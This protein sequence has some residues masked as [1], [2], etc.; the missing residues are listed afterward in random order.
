[1][2]PVLILIFPLL[3]LVFLFVYYVLGLKGL[4]NE[5][6]DV[7]LLSRFPY[8][9]LLEKK[10]SQRIVQTIVFFL[11][12][13]FFGFLP[14]Y[15]T[16]TYSE[17]EGLRS[18]IFGIMMVNFLSIVALLYMVIGARPR[19]PK[20]FLVIYIIY[21]TLATASFSM[22]GIMM[23][24]L[25]KQNGLLHGTNNSLHYLFP[26]LS[27]FFALSEIGLLFNPGLKRWDRLE[28]VTNEDGST[29]F[30]RPSFFP[31]AFNEEISIIVFAL[32]QAVIHLGFFLLGMH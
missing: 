17:I 23:L 30:V 18:Y 25:I 26:I 5:E 22:Y 7:H 9:L 3:A 1:M 14:F 11:F 15:L 10:K 21:A 8:E 6:K 19:S 27:F 32:G 28:K 20:L 31:L 16:S 2:S 29:S 13:V 12:A 4:K 24:S